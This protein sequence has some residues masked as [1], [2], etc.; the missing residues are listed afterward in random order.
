MIIATTGS[1]RAGPNAPIV[2][3]GRYEDIFPV[4]AEDGYQG[5]ELHIQD[6]REIDREGLAKQLKKNRLTLTSIGTGAAYGA[7]HW[8]IGDHDKEIRKKAIECLKEH[9]I[10][11]APHRA[12]IIIGSMQGR[13][14]DAASE[15]EFVN[16]VEESLDILDRLAGQYDDQRVFFGGSSGDTFC[17]DLSCGSGAFKSGGK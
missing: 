16:N 1:L 12:L 5:V 13:F 4:I 17:S 6:S 9:M 3:R 15:E 10:T 2:Y 11:A 14:R 7:W 8:N